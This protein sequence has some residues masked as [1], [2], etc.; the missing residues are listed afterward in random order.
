[1]TTKFL[2]IYRGCFPRRFRARTLCQRTPGAALHSWAL[3]V[4]RVLAEQAALAALYILPVGSACSAEDSPS[5]PTVTVYYADLDLNKPEAV[6]TLYQR[7][8]AAAQEVCA[9]ADSDVPSLESR[10]R[11]AA[12]AVS[13]AVMTVGSSALIHYALAKSGA[14]SSTWVPAP[15]PADHFLAQIQS[16]NGE[17]R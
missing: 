16:T 1:M 9:L 2:L 4:A 7:I 12:E 11:C 13:R 5:I 14:Q 10:E 6:R 17:S 8:V 3:P 15:Q